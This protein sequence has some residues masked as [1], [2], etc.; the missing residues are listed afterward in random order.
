MCRRSR[1]LANQAPTDSG[2]TLG[3]VLNALMKA[4]MPGKTAEA[5]ATPA[6]QSGAAT[7]AAPAAKANITRSAAEGDGRLSINIQD[8]DIRQVLDM[9]SQQGNLNILASDKVAGQGLGD[10]QRRGSR[11]RAEGHPQIDRLAVARARASSS[12]SARPRTSR[13]WS[14]RSTGSAPASTTPAT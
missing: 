4:G 13:P 1:R 7:P 12:S 5:I 3:P 9:L 14:T 11:Q 2:V 10:A 6:G 8:A